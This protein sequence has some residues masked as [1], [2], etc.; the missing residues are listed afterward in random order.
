MSDPRDHIAYGT[1]EAYRQFIAETLAGAETHANVARTYA[2]IGNDA[3]LAYA[4]RC[5]VACTKASVSA[6]ADLN[7][8][9]AEQA[10]RRQARPIPTREERA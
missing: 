1:P 7:D 8:M 3:G 10:Q 2:E 5:L 9:K 6:M 4:I